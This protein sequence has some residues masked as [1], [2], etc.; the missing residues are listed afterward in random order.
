MKLNPTTLLI[1]AMFGSFALIL[2]AMVVIFR[3]D[4]KPVRR[5]PVRQVLDT[6][7]QVRQTSPDTPAT[8]I[9]QQPETQTPSETS[10]KPKTPKQ[11]PVMP[12]G[13]VA[14]QKLY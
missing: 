1:L 12:P 13:A 5:R 14:N 2:G 3:P 6:T 4:P 11:P 8:S 9:S 7:T 10:S